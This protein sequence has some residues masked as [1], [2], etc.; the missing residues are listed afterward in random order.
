MPTV[1]PT[2]PL[3][4][5]LPDKTMAD[6]P[7]TGHESTSSATL[8]SR[9]MQSIRRSVA[10]V[11][12]IS[13]GVPVPGDPPPPPADINKVGLNNMQ[14]NFLI[15]IRDQ[16]RAY[17]SRALLL[18]TSPDIPREELRAFIAEV[19][20]A[21]R[22]R[23]PEYEALVAQLRTANKD[24]AITFAAR[25]WTDSIDPVADLLGEAANARPHRR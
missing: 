5:T 9:G 20:A 8:L 11:F 25:I 12:A 13:G 16:F 3:P 6:G 7:A 15:T 24:A 21:L 4:P 1:P 23:Q 10:G 14:K 19:R 17:R 2:T 22:E 18:R